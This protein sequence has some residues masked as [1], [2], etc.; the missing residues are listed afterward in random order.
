[1]R[2]KLVFFLILLLTSG[3]VATHAEQVETELVTSNT[4]SRVNF[5]LNQSDTI[6]VFLPSELLPGDQITA[7]VQLE[8]ENPKALNG[9]E[10]VLGSEARPVEA[11]LVSWSIPV[12]SENKTELALFRGKAEELARLAIPLVEV[13]TQSPG[14][15]GRDGSGLRLLPMQGKGETYTAVPPDFFDGIEIVAAS[16]RGVVVLDTLVLDTRPDPVLCCSEGGPCGLTSCCD[17]IPSSSCLHCNVSGYDMCLRDSG[18]PT[19]NPD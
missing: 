13:R 2:I 5:H 9:L 7:R 19:P 1:M 6:S 14:R 16:P 10:L 15:P 8:V 4:L 17:F 12:A 18:P 11:S 3:A